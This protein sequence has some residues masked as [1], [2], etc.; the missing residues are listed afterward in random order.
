MIPTIHMPQALRQCLLESVMG[1]DV[2]A[3]VW[4]DRERD[5]MDD[6]DEILEG[7]NHGRS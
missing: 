5:V 7:V 3:V 4:E 6:I 1:P 2:Q